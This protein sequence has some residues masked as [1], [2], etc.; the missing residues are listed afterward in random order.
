MQSRKWWNKGIGLTIAAI[1]QIVCA[2]LL[3]DPA[4]SAMKINIGWGV[5][6]VSAVF[7]WLPIFTFRRKGEIADKSY[8]STTVLVDSGVYQIV[9]HPQY[10]AGILFSLSLML[11]CQ[12]WLVIAL[13]AISTALIYL[14]IREADQEGIDKFGDEYRAYMQ[15]V[16]RANILLGIIRYF[17]HE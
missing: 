17:S 8:V 1:G 3:Y 5:M 12:H 15:R 16:P 9:R 7:G 11:L 2:F 14:D 4:A 13:G 6:L 10:L